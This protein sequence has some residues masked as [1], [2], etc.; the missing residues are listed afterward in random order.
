MVSDEK[1]LLYVMG[2]KSNA[3]RT[4]G[5]LMLAPLSTISLLTSI[6]VPT[7]CLENRPQRMAIGTLTSYRLGYQ[8]RSLAI[9]RASHPHIHLKDPI[10]YLGVI[11]QPERSPLNAMDVEIEMTRGESLAGEWTYLN[12]D[13]AV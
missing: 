3:G 4:P 1:A 5:S 9:S 6:L 7:V 13:S 12:V 10:D 11:L 8:M 2:T